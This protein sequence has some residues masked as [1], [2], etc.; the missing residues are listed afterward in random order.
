M[1]P[2]EVPVNDFDVAV[3]RWVEALNARDDRRVVDGALSPEVV[4]LRYGTGARS[5]EV[6]ERLRD[7]ESVAEW[8]SRTPAGT[9]FMVEESPVPL[10]EDPTQAEVRYRVFAG[11][12]IGHGTWR[13]SLD[14]AGRIAW[15]EHVPDELPDGEPPEDGEAE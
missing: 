4:V 7:L 9:R 6:V 11:D 14:A 1:H 3:A 15:L 5:G 12:F 8:L 10:D 13:L 2:E